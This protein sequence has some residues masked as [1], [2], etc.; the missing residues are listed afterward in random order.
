MPSTPDPPKHPAPYSPSVI[1]AM[2]TLVNAEAQ[3]LD[4]D[5][6]QMMILDPMAGT[7]RVHQ[8][9]GRTYGIEI[10][11]EWAAMHLD[12]KV[13]NALDLPYSDDTFHVVCVSPAYGNRFADHHNARDGSVRRSYTHDLGR[14]LDPRSSG[15][16]AYGLAY[17]QLHAAAWTE[18]TRVL[19]PGGLFV[20][21]VSDFVKT[22][23]PKGNRREVIVPVAEWHLAQLFNLGYRLR[24]CETVATRRM[25]HGANREARVDGE[26]V[27]A[28]RSPA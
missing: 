8:L 22:I 28:L 2:A 23:G 10:E 18:A 15:A 21:N 14:P 5:P 3:R 20:L 6:E 1:K 12:T 26:I 16:L 9:V 4:M 25:R 11:P 24:S 27:A 17:K 19:K 13:G 7:G